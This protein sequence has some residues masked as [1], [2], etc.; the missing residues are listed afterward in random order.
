MKTLKLNLNSLEGKGDTY[1]EILIDTNG[2]Y[3]VE[4]KGQDEKG[5]F[6]VIRGQIPNPINGGG[7]IKDFLN[8]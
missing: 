1:I 4:M 6:R 5:K 7:E 8:R 3:F 2:D